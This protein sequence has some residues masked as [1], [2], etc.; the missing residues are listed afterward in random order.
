MSASAFSLGVRREPPDLETIPQ[1]QSDPM[2]DDHT[3]SRR[4]AEIITDI[5]R[6]HSVHLP[7][8]E[9]GGKA[10]GEKRETVGQNIP[11]L[12]SL[13]QGSGIGRPAGELYLPAAFLIEELFFQSGDIRRDG[14]PDPFP[15]LITNFMFKDSR[16]P[17]FFGGPAGIFRPRAQPRQ[18]SLLDSILCRRMISQPEIRVPVEIVS[19]PVDPRLRI[20]FFLFRHLILL[21]PRFF[22]GNFT[23]E[24]QRAQRN[25]RGYHQIQFIE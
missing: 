5:F 10:G 2:Q 25:N 3:V 21:Q 23:A 1:A 6:L 18:K 22:V 11:E 16:Q 12:F 4:N 24:T 13:K 15:N 19:I 17:G 8:R 7:E 20:N 9:D 14:I